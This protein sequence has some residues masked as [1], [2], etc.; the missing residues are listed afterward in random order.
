MGSLACRLIF[1][2]FAGEEFDLRFFYAEKSLLVR[3]LGVHRSDIMFFSPV[4][5]V[6][7]LS[8]SGLT[9]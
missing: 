9:I 5:A 8:S 6:P 2:I 1:E 3:G 7:A 4:T